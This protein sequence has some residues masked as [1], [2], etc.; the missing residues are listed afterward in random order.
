MGQVQGEE[1]FPMLARD[2]GSCTQLVAI[3][4]RRQDGVQISLTEF[5]NRFWD[6]DSLSGTRIKGRQHCADASHVL[7]WLGQFQTAVHSAKQD[8]RLELGTRAVVG[9][10]RLMLCN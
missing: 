8:L 5:A 4:V 1:D 3:G 7:A 6:S 10:T 2:V 9:R